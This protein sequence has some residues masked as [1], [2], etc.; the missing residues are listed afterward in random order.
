MAQA[1]AATKAPE[2]AAPAAPAAD[3]GA[4]HAPRKKGG[5]LM[6]IGALLVVL[7]AGGGAAAW[8]FGREHGE[9]SESVHAKAPMFAPLDQFTVNLQPEDGQQQYMQIGLTLQV[10][11]ESVIEALKAHMPDVRNRVL[12]L[13]SSKKPS[14]VSTLEGKQKLAEEVLATVSAPLAPKA[15]AKPKADAKSAAKGEAKAKAGAD[16]EKAPEPAQGVVAV[17]FT[18]FIV[19]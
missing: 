8:Y 2:P 1:A 18:H 9:G 13:L 15:P 17:L 19:Q 12:L 11:D 7:A 16:K 10:S 3:A 6:M 4:P 5:K 14:E